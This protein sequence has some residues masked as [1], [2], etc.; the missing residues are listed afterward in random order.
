MAEEPE[1]LDMNPPV[2]PKCSRLAQMSARNRVMMLDFA[3][4][5]VTWDRNPIDPY[6]MTHGQNRPMHRA[7]HRHY[8]A[9][10][11]L[12]RRPAGLPFLV[13]RTTW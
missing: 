9:G 2:N 8:S 12:G 4:N 1:L 13:V 11:A 7:C 10:T 6:A 3:R 5:Q